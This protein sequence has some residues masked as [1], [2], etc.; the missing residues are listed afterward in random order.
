[1]EFID[2]V[3]ASQHPRSGSRWR[4]V[5]DGLEG[6]TEVILHTMTPQCLEYYLKRIAQRIQ[7]EKNLT[8]EYRCKNIEIEW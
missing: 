5:E 6:Q 4:K 8:H 7:V 2:V 1:M 3:H